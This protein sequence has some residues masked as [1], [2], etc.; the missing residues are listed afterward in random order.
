MT[1]GDT[2]VAVAFLVGLLA[3]VITAFCAWVLLT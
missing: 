3:M 2:M 1:K